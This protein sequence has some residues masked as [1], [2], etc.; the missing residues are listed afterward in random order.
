M[1]GILEPSQLPASYGTRRGAP[2]PPEFI[3]AAAKRRWNRT[4]PKIPGAVPDGG[5]WWTIR[6]DLYEAWLDTQRARVAGPPVADTTT[7]SQPWSPATA[8][9]DA[10]L[11]AT[12]GAP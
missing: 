6:R 8:L 9:R 10:G 3:G 11:R 12:R 1:S 5:R 4:L 7:T 2:I